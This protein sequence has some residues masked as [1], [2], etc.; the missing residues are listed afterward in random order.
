MTA[1]SAVWDWHGE[2]FRILQVECHRALVAVQILEVRAMAGASRLLPAGIL[3]QCIDFDDIG[4]PIC[5][6]SHTGRPG[7]DAGKIDLQLRPA[8]SVRSIPN[9]IAKAGCGLGGM[10]ARSC[11]A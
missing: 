2:A 3:Q 8:W 10:K 11:I 4:A 5:Q 9:S 6:L 1:A 7:T